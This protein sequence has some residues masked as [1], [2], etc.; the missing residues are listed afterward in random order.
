MRDVPLVVEGPPPSRREGWDVIANQLLSYFVRL[1]CREPVDCYLGTLIEFTKISEGGGG[2]FRGFYGPSIPCNDVPRKG[3][4]TRGYIPQGKCAWE[5]RIKFRS[6][7]PLGTARLVGTIA[8]WE[9]D[10]G[11]LF[12]ISRIGW[13]CDRHQGRCCSNGSCFDLC[14]CE[15]G[16]V[17]GAASNQHSTRELGWGESDRVLGDRRG[18]GVL[19][20]RGLRPF[21]ETSEFVTCVRVRRDNDSP[22]H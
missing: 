2:G 20:G 18:V 5:G 6:R 7:R 10:H 22:A 15:L 21:L 4:S 12:H 3:G 19:G 9:A 11:V 17:D 8:D 14:A 16:F 1:S 13:G